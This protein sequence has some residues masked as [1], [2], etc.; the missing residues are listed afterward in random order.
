MVFSKSEEQ[1][2][3]LGARSEWQ[4]WDGVGGWTLASSLT[5]SFEA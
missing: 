2:G 1:A 3:F 4:E 5:T